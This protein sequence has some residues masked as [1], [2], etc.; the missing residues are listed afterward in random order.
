MVKSP[1]CLLSS[2]HRRTHMV[3]QITYELFKY[4]FAFKGVFKSLNLLFDARNTKKIY[5]ADLHRKRPKGRPIA[6]WKDD[7]E[8]GGR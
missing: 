3:I 1:I 2:S 8:N 6:K 5:Q 7:V 4:P